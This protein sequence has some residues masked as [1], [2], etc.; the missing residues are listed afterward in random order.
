MK[1]DELIPGE[2][3]ILT[4][5]TYGADKNDIVIFHGMRGSWAICNSIDEP[6]MQDSIVARPEQLKPLEEKVKMREVVVKPVSKYVL[7]AAAC[8]D[9]FYGVEIN[10]YKNFITREQFNSGNFVIRAVHSL[11]NGNGYGAY[12]NECLRTLIEKAIENNNK[13]FEFDSFNDL[14]VWLMRK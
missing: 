11:T 13:V 7:A 4:R 2:K 10:G 3:Y 1:S 8:E 6:S 12:G 9:K 5:P 14:A